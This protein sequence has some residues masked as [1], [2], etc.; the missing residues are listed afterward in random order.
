MI[1][2]QMSNDWREISCSLTFIALKMGWRRPI[3]FFSPFHAPLH[4]CDCQM[5]SDRIE[6]EGRAS[7][8]PGSKSY[9][10]TKDWDKSKWQFIWCLRKLKMYIYLSVETIWCGETK[11][12]LKPNG[13]LLG[14]DSMLWIWLKGSR[15]IFSTLGWQ[16]VEACI[17]TIHVVRSSPVLSLCSYTIY[18]FNRN[19][20][21]RNLSLRPKVCD[22]LKGKML[23]GA[24]L[25]C[26]GKP[27]VMMT[28]KKLIVFREEVIRARLGLY[29]IS[30]THY[31]VKKWIWVKAGQ[32]VPNITTGGGK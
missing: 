1:V 3:H 10:Q 23:A 31:T 17:K 2:W 9:W 26:F 20:R 11:Q 15:V 4:L 16:I 19:M 18:C 12:N 24:K 21:A 32:T 25:L 6:I 14:S 8:N 28:G 5:A 30:T 22:I 29:F 27:E 7:F 13:V